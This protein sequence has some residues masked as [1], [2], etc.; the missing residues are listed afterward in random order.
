MGERVLYSI[1]DNVA[2]ITLNRPEK[3][4]A[5]DDVTINELRTYF[6][7]A[8]GDREVRVIVFKGEGPAFSAGADLDYLLKISKNSS[9]SNYEDSIGLRELLMDIYRSR[10]LVCA[11]V[12]GPALA[13][14]FGLVL[15]CDIVFASELGKFGF[16]EVK[17]GFVPA[18]V[19][20]LALRKMPESHA[21]FLLLTGKIIDASEALKMGI[22]RDI[23]T[24]GE[25]E[26]EVTSTLKEFVASTSGTAIAL[27][28]EL[29]A[30]AKD[31]P[32][33]TA[34]QYGAMMNAAA[35]STDDFKIGINS[36]INKKKLEWR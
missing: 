24:D 15:A 7:N 9:L 4:N 23:I 13:G 5:L 36:F 33:D 16:T 12:R 20:N 10:K 27:T 30:T 3:R 11:V 1:S 18:I 17:I 2:Y 8:E 21:R 25:I 31:L 6:K 28:K 26:E 14:G 32:F 29:L 35:R 19:L 22:V 34:M